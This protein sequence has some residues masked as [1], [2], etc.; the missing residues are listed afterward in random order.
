MV[1]LFFLLRLWLWFRYRLAFP[2]TLKVRLFLLWRQIRKSWL[3]ALCIHS[4]VLLSPR[5][6]IFLIKISLLLFLRAL[7][8][9][10]R[11]RSPLMHVLSLLFTLEPTEWIYSIQ[12]FM[13]VIAVVTGIFLINRFIFM[14][15]WI[16]LSFLFPLLDLSLNL[17][18]YLLFSLVGFSAIH[19]IFWDHAFRIPDL[20][21]PFASLPT[22]FVK[23]AD[24]LC[25][26]FDNFLPQLNI[27]SS[28]GTDLLGED[29]VL[30]SCLF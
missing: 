2:I 11:I 7:I 14:F 15:V 10:A 18:F 8:T 28:K 1:L 3:L 13:I 12:A 5:S 29:Y 20:F 6:N 30:E 23:L 17:L 9:I 27:L 26:H 19:V 4:S 16:L 25:A 24:I 21:N 22:P